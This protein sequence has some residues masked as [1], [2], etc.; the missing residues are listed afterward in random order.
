V[1]VIERNA[2]LQHQ[3]VEDLLDMSRLT[4]GTLRLNPSRVAL[5]GLLRDAI[6]VVRPAADARQIALDVQMDPGGATIVGDST[7]LQQVLWNL[8]TN[9]LK[10]TMPG[11]VVVASLRADDGHAEV[12]IRDTGIGIDASFLPF[13]FDPFR[14]AQDRV[15][16]TD[17]GLG[18]GLTI[19]RQL[20]ELHGG[21]IT[22][23]S[24]GLGHGA[25][26]VVRLPMRRG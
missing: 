23:S 25:T 11:G 15:S 1:E 16:R 26:F 22:A 13:V 18:L 14:Q 8:L 24:A 20:V 7:R 6:D 21:T 5:E 12:A 17:A 10:F 4:T 9:A 2:V 19:S 3:L